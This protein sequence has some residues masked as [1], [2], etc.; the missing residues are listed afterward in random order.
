[1]QKA[2]CQQTGLNL[3]LIT[4]AWRCFKTTY[5]MLFHFTWHR[6]CSFKHDFYKSRKHLQF[7]FLKALSSTQQFFPHGDNSRPRLW[8]KGWSLHLLEDTTHPDH[9]SQQQHKNHISLNKAQTVSRKATHHLSD[10]MIYLLVKRE[11]L[12]L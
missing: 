2:N 9:T 6:N 12:M 10:F 8:S 7:F 1:M 3:V 4:S 5:I 11:A